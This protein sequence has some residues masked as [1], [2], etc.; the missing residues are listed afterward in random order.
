MKNG[1]ERRDFL[2]TVGTGLIGAA[3]SSAMAAE[4]NGDKPGVGTIADLPKRRLGRIGIDVPPLSFGTAAMGHAFYRA[5]PF[6]EVVNAA[7]DAGVTYMD[8]ARLYDVAEDRLAPIL[9]KRRKELF[10]VTK[11]WARS[12]DEALSALEQSLTAM[13]VDSVD[14]IHLHNVG[15]YTR[16]EAL[17]KGGLLEG[18][19]EARKRGWCEF[20]GCSGH[21]VPARFIPIIDTGEIDLIMVAMNFVDR[22]TYNFEERLLPV[23][24]KHDCGIVCMKVYGGV[25]GSWDGYKK[26]RPGRLA[27]DEHRQTAFDYALSIPDVATCVVGLKT[28]DELRLA[29]QAVRN[30]KP[31]DGKRREEVTTLGKQMAEEWADHLGPVHAN[32]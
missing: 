16:E 7:I 27:S 11:A 4:T 30:F 23:A 6:E 15:Q 25:T 3:A 26:R 19:L 10:L 32:A 2:R 1:L 28:L 13:Q 8:T 5:E 17:G 18:V 21:G 9:A 20:I 31:L 24:R 29:I 12:R 22:H 14:L